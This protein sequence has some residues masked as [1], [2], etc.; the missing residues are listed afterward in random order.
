M[1]YENEL[2]LAPRPVS[3]FE[4]QKLWVS[5]EFPFEDFPHSTAIAGANSDLRALG[6]AVEAYSSIGVSPNKLV[7]GLPWVSLM[8]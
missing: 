4:S 8:V 1:K 6:R 5:D 2:N 3:L 7:I